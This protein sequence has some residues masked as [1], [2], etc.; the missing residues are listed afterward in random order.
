MVEIIATVESIEQAQQLIPYVDTLFFGE[1]TFGLRLPASFS[2]EEQI[3]LIDMAHEAGKKV[4]IAVN[5]I[6]HP[7]KMK[8]IP[9]YLAFLKT[10]QADQ[11]ALGDPGI[12][13]R[14]KQNPECALPFIYAGETLVTSARQI[15]F[16][17][18]KGAKAAV[19]A[20]EVP[21]EEMK[22]MA[23]QLNIPVE[24]LVYGATCIHQSKRPLLQ[25][26]YNYTQQSEEKNHDRGL[27]LSEPKKEETHYSIY[28][29]S[30]GTHIFANNDINLMLQLAEL[31]ATGF[32]TWKLDG[33]YT[34]GAAFVAIAKLF[35]QA[36]S[37]VESGK[38]QAEQ[39]AVLSEQVAQLHPAERG[40]DTG[41]YAIDPDDIK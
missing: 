22:I 3:R 36:K 4:T 8:R 17:G 20:R 15:N 38:W 32:Q 1:E 14:M 29:D 12:I 18:Q 28:E 35:A 34:R 9:E 10:N 30:H 21:F 25:N 31:A 13:Y 39:A 23:P 2:R 6:M 19:V 40:L 5:G 27:F 26:Y 37:L 16:W 11:I 7:E 24:V 33:I 41:F